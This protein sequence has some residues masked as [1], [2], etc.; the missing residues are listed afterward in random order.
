MKEHAGKLLKTLVAGMRG[1]IWTGK[2]SFFEATAR[3]VECCKNLFY[4]TAAGALDLPKPEDIIRAMLVEAKKK[5][6]EYKKA[7]I[8][9]LA[10]VLGNIT[11]AAKLA[12]VSSAPIYLQV[13]GTF[14]HFVG[15]FIPSENFWL[16]ICF[17]MIYL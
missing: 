10:S 2:E 1:R 16:I 5:N 7:A 11:S 6:I 17:L 4:D 15:G 3:L 9:A 14:S 13:Q 8:V 12:Q